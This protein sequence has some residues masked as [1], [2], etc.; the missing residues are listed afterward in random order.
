MEPQDNI[1]RL[2]EFIGDD[3]NREG[4]RETPDR[5]IRSYKELFSGYKQDPASVFKCFEDGACDEMVVLSGI[6]FCSHCEHHMLPFLG[7]AHVAYIPNKRIIGVS[8][9]ARLVEIFARR[10]QVQERLTTQITEALDKHL[11]PLGSACMIEANHLCMS[12]RGVRKQAIMR[13]SSLTGAFK[14]D[15]VARAEF[16]ALIKG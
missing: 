13:T 2:I 10:L 16:L 3:P 1:R 12:C 5:V 8:K 11:Q 6:E 15:G 14:Q 4:L 9:I 7:H